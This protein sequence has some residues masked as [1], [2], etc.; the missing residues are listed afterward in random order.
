VFNNVTEFA[1]GGNKVRRRSGRYQDLHSSRWEAEKWRT[2]SDA[3]I[4]RQGQR[5]LRPRLQAPNLEIAV[6]LSRERIH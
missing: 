6:Q 5:E 1:R 4:E 3:R 2:S